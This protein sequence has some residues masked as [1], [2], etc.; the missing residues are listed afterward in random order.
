MRLF[1][2]KLLSKMSAL[3]FPDKM[4]AKLIADYGSQQVDLYKKQLEMDACVRPRTNPQC[5]GGFCKHTDYFESGKNW[6]S[7]KNKY[8]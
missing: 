2:F 6:Y 4:R 8:K 1:L 7:T 5:Q 3:I